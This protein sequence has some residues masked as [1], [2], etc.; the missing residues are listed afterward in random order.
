LKEDSKAVQV[1]AGENLTKAYA[2]ISN[3]VSE[4]RADQ[5]LLRADVDQLTSKFDEN[6]ETIKQSI[7]EQV[8]TVEEKLD[9]KLS[10]FRRASD[11]LIV[12][13]VLDKTVNRCFE[14]LAKEEL[15]SQR[16]IINKLEQSILNITTNRPAAI[17]DDERLSCFLEQK[18]GQGIEERVLDR[19]NHLDASYHHLS[20][21]I[22]CLA[23]CGF[24]YSWRVPTS[25]SSNQN[26]I[27]SE[28]FQLC[29]AWN[30]CFIRFFPR[31]E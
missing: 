21:R 23:Q 17:E 4:V 2:S 22:E 26:F 20:D 1:E 25:S 7:T 11:E 27:E 30:K 9:S 19:F 28:F 3:V 12:A 24:S 10:E 13:D 15:S 5:N 29:P 8:E 6:L 16:E 18:I 14:K 31:G